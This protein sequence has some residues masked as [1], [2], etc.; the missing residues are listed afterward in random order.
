MNLFVISDLHLGHANILN[1]IIDDAGTKLRPEFKNVDYMDET[2]IQ[3]WNEVVKPGDHVYNLG[4]VAMNKRF[5]HLNLRLNGKKRLIFGNHD[6]FDYQDYAEA[7]F[8]KMMG[9]RVLDGIIFTHVPIHQSQLERFKAN[10]HG[11]THSNHVKLDSGHRDPRY[12]NVCVEQ[13][14][15]TPVPLEEIKKRIK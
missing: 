10:V 3:R 5:L 2:I 14:N 8:Q 12:L 9:M 7:G 4:D 1:F 13:V 11:H 15:Y 6:I